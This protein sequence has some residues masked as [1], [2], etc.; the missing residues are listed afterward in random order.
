MNSG[1]LTPDSIPVGT[2]CRLLLIPD[3]EAWIAIITGAL[4]DLAYADSWQEYGA[5]TPEQCAGR[6]QQMV[7][8]FVFN[9][10]CPP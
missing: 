8:D 3:D 2:T 9:G 1:Y 5:L 10:N 7:D 6:M 4:Q